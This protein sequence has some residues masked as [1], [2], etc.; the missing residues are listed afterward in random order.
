MTGTLTDEHTEELNALRKRAYGPDA[1][2]HQDPEALRRLRELEGAA[3]KREPEPV[4]IEPARESTPEPAQTPV[5]SP[6]L[7]IADAEHPSEQWVRRL[8]RFR[9]STVLI[10]IAVA[11]IAAII[12]AALVLVQR[13]QTDPLQ[14]GANQVARLTVDAEYKIPRF[15]YSDRQAFTA[16]YGL[17]VVVTG[18][19]T[20]DR[21]LNIYADA[22]ILDPN[23]SSF[24]GGALKG[25]C[26]AGQFPAMTQFRVD[27]LSL[28]DELQ[29]AFPNSDALQFV[30]DEANNEVVIFAE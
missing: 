7:N 22:D 2:I 23:A 8:P 17:R 13:V 21:C 16:F 6:A 20:V 26:A 12:A 5:E 24:T 1:D 4:A 27:A 15:F 29:A 30:Y 19:G 3:A 18:G 10:A 11:V 9:R 28:P 14:V 25:G